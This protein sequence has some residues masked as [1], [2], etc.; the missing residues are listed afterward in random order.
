MSYLTRKLDFYLDEWK[1]DPSHMPLIVKGPRQVGKTESI[2]H[3]AIANYSSFIEINF[4]TEPKYKKIIEDG[5]RPEDIIKNITLLNPYLKFEKKKTLLF[6]DEIQAFPNITT[7]LKFFNETKDYDVICSGSLI[8]INYREIES[9]SVGN[10]IDYNMCSMD[11]EEFLWAKGYDLDIK[12][13]LL[14][15]LIT[16]KGFNKLELSLF[17]DL[18][19]TYSILGGMPAVIS[20]YIS[21]KNFAGSLIRQRQIIK[22]YEEDIK[23]YAVGID[24]SRVLDAYRS[25]VPQLGKENKKFQ[26]SKINKDARFSTY[27]GAVNWLIDS[28]I[29]NV[30]YA[31]SFPSL[32]L[33]GN[34][35]ESKFKLYYADTGLLVASLDE[36]SSLDLR[37]NKNMGVYKGALYENVI[38]EALRKSGYDL[39]YYSRPSSHLEEDFFLRTKS[40]I[41]PL[42]VKATNGNSKSLKTLIEDD[43][44][45]LIKWGIKLTNKNISYENNI[46]TLPHFMASF[47]KDYLSSLD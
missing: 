18:F 6:F 2:R 43:R 27:S 12:K 35:D 40:Y 32:P 17:S 8:G 41:V 14:K 23:K 24:Q 39:Y 37:E 44:Y 36:E 10:K 47:L 15:H 26:I 5:F 45:P 11:W 1:K 31:L 29:V 25:V 21:E 7:S 42:E 34:Y 38:A 46:L 4:V 22:D 28:G 9:L 30:C 19:L 3:F 16:R 33:K 13:Q 20:S